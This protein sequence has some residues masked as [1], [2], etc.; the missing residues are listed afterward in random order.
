MPGFSYGGYGDGTNWSSER[1]SGPAPG[2]GS[3]GNAGNRGGGSSQSSSSQATAEQEQMDTIRNNTAVRQK[4]A[5]IIKAARKF[6]PYAKLTIQSISQTGVMSIS[7]TELNAE[8]ASKIGLTGMIMGVDAAGTKMAI[9]NFP[10]G[11]YRNNKNKKF[12]HRSVPAPASIISDGSVDLFTYDPKSGT[13]T[14]TKYFAKVGSLKSLKITGPVNY[15]LYLDFPGDKAIDVTINKMD[16][17]NITVTFNNWSG[18]QDTTRDGIKKLIKEFIAFK[19][20]EERDFLIQASA[21]IVSSGQEISKRLGVKY[22]NLA[23]EIAAN[24]KNFQGKTVRNID[25]AMVTLN[26][27]LANPKMK[28]KAGDKSA[29]LNAWSHLNATDMAYKFGFLGKTFSAADIA[30]KIEN[31][32]KKT[33]RAIDTGDWKPALLEVESW[34]LSGVATGIALS[35]LASLS[36]FLAATVGLPATMVTVLGIM[37]I[38]LAAS[39]IDDKLADKI[40]NWLVSPAY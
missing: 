4:L 17:N 39:L 16:P 28:I 37:G 15:R 32:R 27:L 34:I 20:T 24:I 31:L 18:P 9:G 13:Y 19:L 8:Q 10:T 11:V 14:S 7:V 33:I 38:A 2:G 35:I 23:N 12:E 40:N 36:T 5:D 26:K 1:G 22:K 21:V 29:L 6:N 30:I 3:T 25:S